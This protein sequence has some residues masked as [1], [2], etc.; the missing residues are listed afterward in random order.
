MLGEDHSPG[1]G[2]CCSRGS[3]S[4]S[5]SGPDEDEVYDGVLGLPI[6]PPLDDG[7]LKERGGVS[8]WPTSQK[9]RR[10]QTINR[11]GSV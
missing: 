5:G 1:L 2:G 9:K 11:A 7:L 8:T 6:L 10:T 3:G 4:G